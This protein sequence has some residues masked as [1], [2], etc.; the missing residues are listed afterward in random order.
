VSVRH[1]AAERDASPAQRAEQLRAALAAMGLPVEVEPR[2]P[3]AV[4]VA[5]EPAATRLIDASFRR[6][7]LGV[8]R[9][10]GF[11]HVAIELGDT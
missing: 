10:H 11:T 4:L 3:L 6:A 7:V 9:E 5:A 1:Q 2:A 8:A